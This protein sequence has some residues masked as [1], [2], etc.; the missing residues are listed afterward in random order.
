MISE[1]KQTMRLAMRSAL[2]G[3]SATER[4]AASARVAA[5]V[6]AEIG[7][8]GARV[9][10]GFAPMASEPDWW[11]GEVAGVRFGFPRVVGVGLEFR[12]GGEPGEMGDGAM[13]VREPVVTAGL[14]DP[15]EADLV[16]VPGLAFDRAGGRLGRGGGFYDRFLAGLP[17]G[18][19]RVGVAFDRQIVG[20]VPLGAHDAAVGRVV[21]ERGALACDL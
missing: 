18:V 19:V 7:R 11:G 3:M 12:E 13:G 16:L 9:V 5:E 17:L 8:V 14:I 6:R 1:E 20:A 10:L 2:R 15:R 4:T 21:T